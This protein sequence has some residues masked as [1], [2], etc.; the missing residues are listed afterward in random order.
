MLKSCDQNNKIIIIGD[1]NINWDDKHGRKN[2]KRSTGY[3]NLEQLIEKPTRITNN[4]QTRIDLLFSNKPNRIIKTFNFF[5]GLSDHKMILFSRKLSKKRHLKLNSALHSSDVKLNFIP[6][7]QTQNLNT[8]LKVV[9]WEEIL[10]SNN[11]ESSCNSFI[12]KLKEVM[13]SFTCRGSG[14]AKKRNNLPWLNQTCKDLLKIRDVLLKQYLKSG[15]ST[16][17]EKFTHARK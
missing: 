13:S 17:R 16:D 14:G 9:D 10:R 4:S 2:L 8:A 12:N 1:F 7:N 5:T 6:K 3:F 11:I 15:L